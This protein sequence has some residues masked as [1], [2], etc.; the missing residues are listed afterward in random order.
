MRRKNF[1]LTLLACLGL[2]TFP[3]TVVDAQESVPHEVGTDAAAEEL[4]PATLDSSATLIQTDDDDEIA[5]LIRMIED[6]NARD[7]FNA[8]FVPTGDEL[9]DRYAKEVEARIEA[10]NTS[11]G[12]WTNVAAVPDNTLAEWQ[13]EFGADPRYWELRYFCA[14]LGQWDSQPLEEDEE[15]IA[16]LLEA[17]QRGISTANTLLLLY[18]EMRRE[19]Q[20]ELE[21]VGDAPGGGP[22]L[23]HL[24]EQEE[25]EL[26]DAAVAAGPD[27]AWTYYTR[28]M[29][30]FYLGQ[31][32]RALDDLSVGNI[33]RN[34]AYPVPWPMNYVD[35]A[36]GMDAPPGS[37]AVCGAIWS[38]SIALVQPNFITV[39]DHLRETTICMNL[40]AGVDSLEPWHQF[41]C[42]L[43]QSISSQQIFLLVG[44]IL[45]DMVYGYAEEN[46]EGGAGNDTL[47]RCRGASFILRE[48]IKSNNDQILNSV[49]RSS[50]F[51]ALDGS[52]GLYAAHYL[53]Q[54]TEWRYVTAAQGML[55]DLSQVHYPALDLPP[56][57]LKYSPLTQEDTRRINAE[58]RKARQAASDDV[59]N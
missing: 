36:P 46:C 8:P 4:P 25:L 15:P 40:G 22:E 1:C 57:M 50:L 5:Q 26:L 55:A 45:E 17:Q 18:G 12:E 16:F 47:L 13:S 14:R 20:L 53:S 7:C 6:S 34:N 21:A 23:M 41:A 59:Q 54:F 35:S 49:Q 51:I 2:A 43:G 10:E 28:A 3:L 38:S 27:E 48:I 30:W 9:F 39:K 56:C 58:R 11:S 24:Q 52:R 29:Y 32:E 33:A 19:N 31:Q 37:A 44:T 42:R